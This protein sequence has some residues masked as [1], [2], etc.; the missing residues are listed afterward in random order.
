M[1]N[2]VAIAPLPRP[3]SSG[4]G[5]LVATLLERLAQLPQAAILRAGGW[6]LGLH[7][8]AVKRGAV[9]ALYVDTANLRARAGFAVEFFSRRE[10]AAAVL[11]SLGLEAELSAAIASARVRA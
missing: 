1:P 5:Q 3:I 4:R 2:V 8:E 7:H 11:L 6:T 9:F 10:D